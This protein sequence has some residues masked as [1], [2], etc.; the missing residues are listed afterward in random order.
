M[1]APEDPEISESKAIKKLKKDFSG[2]MAYW[3]KVSHIK[4]FYFVINDKYKGTYPTTEALLSKLKIDHNLIL[5][6]PFLAKH[7]EDTLFDLSDDIIISIVGF[8]PN[9][10]DV[11]MVDYSGL[12][13][14]IVYILENQLPISLVPDL[15]VP[16]FDEKIV[17]NNLN[18]QVSTL[19]NTASYQLGILDDYFE[20]N[21]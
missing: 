2:L 21:R 19:L 10:K 6:E 11:T 12:N 4:E 13:E 18:R 16:N 3:E 5:C 7:L 1:Y 15:S 20:R 8:I 14:V 9:P 17:F